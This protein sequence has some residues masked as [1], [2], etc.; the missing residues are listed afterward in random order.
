M[1]GQP[2][3][4]QTP[5]VVLQRSI[6]SDTKSPSLSLG[7]PLKIGIFNAVKLL[8]KLY[9]IDKAKEIAQVLIDA[10]MP[11]EFDYTKKFR[12]KKEE[13]IDK[14]PEP[15]VQTENTERLCPRCSEGKLV[16]KK[17]KSKKAQ[18]KY[19]SEEFIGCSRYP[20]CRYTESY[21]I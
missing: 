3:N 5:G 21:S 4:F 14:T 8:S 2:L 19:N 1:S 10:H 15:K 18:E 20:K 6:L 16:V 17:I 9:D 7:C 11:V 13:V 12:I